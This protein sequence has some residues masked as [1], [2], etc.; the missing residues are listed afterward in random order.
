MTV[1]VEYGLKSATVRDQNIQIEIWDTAGQEAY[2]SLT[3]SYYRNADGCLIVFDL[4]QRESF[5]KVSKWAEHARQYSN[6]PHLVFTLVGNKADQAALRQV[7]RE[8]A[9]AVAAHQGME[10]REVTAKDHTAVQ[11]LFQ[12]TA[13][14]IFQA[15]E[16]G[17]G[18]KGGMGGSDIVI[19]GAG[20][21]RLR[22]FNSSLS[23]SAFG[24]SPGRSARSQE[25]A[26]NSGK[27][28]CC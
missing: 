18:L 5:E 19:D 8:E 15:F 7:A 4:T 10:Y 26:G 27:G 28:R 25:M 23:S 3:N 6:N 13:E 14:R 17:A 16:T 21:I 2:M 1:G 11:G 24:L 20:K 12:T 22:S 9:E